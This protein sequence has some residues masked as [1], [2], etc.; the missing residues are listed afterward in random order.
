MNTFAPRSLRHDYALFVEREVEAYKEAVSAE[1]LQRI[2]V[3]ALAAIEGAAQIGIRDLLLA[4]EVDR[5]IARR[6]ELP[7]FRTW[8]RR[9]LA[10]A[11]D[12]RR[13]G[14]WTLHLDTPVAHVIGRTTRAA[15]V[16]VGGGRVMAESLYLAANGCRVTAVDP[17]EAMVQRVLGDA[18]EAGFGS[19]VRGL[20]MEVSDYR[21]GGAL[22]GVVCAP[23]V[24]AGLAEY[25]REALV[26]MLQRATLA[27]GVH[28]VESMVAEQT[29]I[30]EEELWERYRGWEVAVV[31]EG[32]VGRALVARKVA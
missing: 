8:S 32:R 9:R 22:A 27:G 11:E 29:A 19:R 18:S 30:T 16:L 21:P 24:F 26:T 10:C 17:D 4:A 1:H 15:P 3:A 13:P 20:T 5:I 2:A 31:R 28:V 14:Y 25:E 7:S 12:P 6:L 23:G